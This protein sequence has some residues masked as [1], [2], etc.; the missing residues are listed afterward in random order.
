MFDD[1]ST[2]Q[3]SSKNGSLRVFNRYT[4]NCI[5]NDLSL[6]SYIGLKYKSCNQLIFMIFSS[7]ELYIFVIYIFC[8]C[9]YFTYEIHIIHNYSTIQIISNVHTISN[10]QTIHTII[11]MQ[12]N[13]LYKYTLLNIHTIQNI[14]NCF[15]YTH[16][17]K[18]HQFIITHKRGCCQEIFLHKKTGLFIPCFTDFH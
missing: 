11:F 8:H 16:N 15:K 18:C 4:G 5:Q 13:E 9:I 1:L 7:Y 2:H 3:K 12:Y 6:K 14:R 17:K 10:I